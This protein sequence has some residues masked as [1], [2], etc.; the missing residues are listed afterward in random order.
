MSQFVDEVNQ[1]IQ[2]EGGRMTAQRRVILEALESCGGHPTAEE[3]FQIAQK[4][5]PTLNLSTVYRTLRWLEKVELVSTHH[6]H[7]GRHQDRFDASPPQEH[8]H[9]RCRCCNCI[10]EFSDERIE[11]IKADFAAA[12]GCE[13]SE[14]SLVLDGLCA[15]CASENS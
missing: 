6:F 15:H 8:H 1:A 5:D 4:S 3:I 10:I 12:F 2:I 13:V 11:Q 14:A 9:F 7:D